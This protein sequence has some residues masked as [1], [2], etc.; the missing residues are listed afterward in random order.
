M[1]SNGFILG[2]K[3]AVFVAGLDSSGAL[4]P[5]EVSVDITDIMGTDG[6]PGDV[7]Q[8]AGNGNAEWQPNA[9]LAYEFKIQY[10]G[11]NIDSAQELPTGWTLDSQDVSTL[12]ISHNTGRI[13]KRVS[14]LVNDGS[15]VKLQDGDDS[16][17]TVS[18]MLEAKNS[19]VL[20]ADTSR[21]GAADSSLGYVNIV[22]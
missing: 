3:L 12:W 10:A 4:P 7:L 8:S 2:S 22:F 13:P 15:V 21:T 20:V 19:F 17:L 18:S 1:A 9:A 11:T 5:T 6:N 14:F 16:C